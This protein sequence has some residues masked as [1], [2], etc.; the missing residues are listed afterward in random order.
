MMSHLEPNDP[1]EAVC[2]ECGEEENITHIEEDIWTCNICK[3]TFSDR[4]NA[5]FEEDI[6]N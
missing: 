2:T 6:R 4:S 1:I 5:T 3:D